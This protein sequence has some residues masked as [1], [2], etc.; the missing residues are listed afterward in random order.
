MPHKPSVLTKEG[1]IAN[2]AF[3]TKSCQ[4]AEQITKF[5]PKSDYC[6]LR[7]VSTSQTQSDTSYCQTAGQIQHSL[8]QQGDICHEIQEH[9]HRKET[10]TR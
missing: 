3:A 5:S 1:I 9:Q 10:A 8:F 6:D 4:K 2:I 7:K